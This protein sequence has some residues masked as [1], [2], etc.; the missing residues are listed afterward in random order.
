M[1][2]K[3]INKLEIKGYTNFSEEEK[4]EIL[5]YIHKLEDIIENATIK[6]ICCGEM[7]DADFQNNMLKILGKK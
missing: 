4:E 6:L 3:T 2:K 1:K 5:E 7:L